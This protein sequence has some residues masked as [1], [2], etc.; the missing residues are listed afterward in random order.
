MK[1]KKLDRWLKEQGILST[2]VARYLGLTKHAISKWRERG[3]IP[4]Y[5]SPQIE[6]LLLLDRKTVQRHLSRQE[7]EL[8]Q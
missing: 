1:T 7:P 8:L 6:E 5:I 4:Q 2:E 3:E